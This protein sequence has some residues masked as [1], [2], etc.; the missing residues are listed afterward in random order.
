MS[1]REL[2]VANKSRPMAVFQDP[3]H[4]RTLLPQPHD[5][6]W[7]APPIRGAEVPSPSPLP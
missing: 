4:A 1:T 6:G 5:L 7:L 2:N 3:L